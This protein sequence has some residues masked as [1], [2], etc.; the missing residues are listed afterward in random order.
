MT[1]MDEGEAKWETARDQ[2]LLPRGFSPRTFQ[3]Q[4][5]IQVR[6]QLLNFTREQKLTKSLEIQRPDILEGMVPIKML[7]DKKEAQREHQ[8]FCA[9]TTGV[10]EHHQLILSLLN[11][12]KLKVPQDRIL[13]RILDHAGCH[14]ADILW[15]EA[16][17]LQPFEEAKSDVTVTL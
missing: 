7:H 5:L 8:F 15:D 3:K 17:R 16:E 10:P 12:R 6:D 9:Q 1:N 4:L 14:S 11:R 2:R 13:R